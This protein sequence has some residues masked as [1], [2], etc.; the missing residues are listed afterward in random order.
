[1]TY[2]GIPKAA[3]DDGRILA[4]YDD[5]K[6]KYYDEDEDSDDPYKTKKMARDIERKR[7]HHLVGTKLKKKVDGEFY[8]GV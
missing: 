2:D 7:R 4:W 6:K 1:M 8:C 3:D 5:V